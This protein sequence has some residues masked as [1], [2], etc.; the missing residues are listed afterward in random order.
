MQEETQ[1]AAPAAK[2]AKP[3]ARRARP[4][5]PQQPTSQL[6]PDLDAADQLAPSQMQQ[7]MP[8]AVPLPGKPAKRAPRTA[9]EHV[10]A[11][12][13]GARSIA[14]SGAFGKDSSHLKLAI[15]FDSRNIT[16]TEVDGGSVGKV[17][18]SVIY[19]NDPK[20]R[21]EVWWHNPAS[22]SDTYLVV[23][24]GQSGW[25]APKGVRLGLPL[26]ALEK[27][28]KKPFKLKGLA[29]SDWDGGALGTL[30]GGCKIGVT[31]TADT[32]APEEARKAVAES[33]D[34]AS[35]DESLRAAKPKVSEI[36][37]GY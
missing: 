23:I 25:M 10:P 33:K 21:L 1:P 19:P 13:P 35:A 17:Q 4:Q 6:Q 12:V 18:A 30:P 15:A 28:N 34:F 11:P 26:S 20:R 27:L 7:P 22:R 8:S 32:S 37:I 31:L 5:Q 3:P 14:C 29:V 9:A 24:G 16:F 2:P 36:I